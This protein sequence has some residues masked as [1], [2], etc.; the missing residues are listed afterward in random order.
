MS[1]NL[2]YAPYIYINTFIHIYTYI[3]IYRY[4]HTFIKLCQRYI[5]SNEEKHDVQLMS[6]LAQSVDLHPIE[7]V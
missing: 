2:S 6:W 3:Y 1:G 5:K 4:T 7:L